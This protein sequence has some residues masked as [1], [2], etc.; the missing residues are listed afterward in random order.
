[1]MSDMTP[2]QEA[3][4]DEGKKSAYQAMLWMLIKESG[5]EER[6]QHGWRIERFHTVR[7]LREVC[8][9]LGADNTWPDDLDLSDVIEKYILRAIDD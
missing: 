7:L 4:F 2:E 6:S 9:K 1:M 3:A 8:V 5:S